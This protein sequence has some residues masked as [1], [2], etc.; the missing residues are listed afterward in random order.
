[1][2]RWVRSLLCAPPAIPTRFAQQWLTPGVN[3]S[4]ICFN[5]VVDKE[6]MMNNNPSSI[7]FVRTQT[8]AQGF[9]NGFGVLRSLLRTIVVVTIGAVAIAGCTNPAPSGTSQTLSV[10][11]SGSGSGA[12]TS[13]T[14]G[15]NCG[16]TCSAVVE[17]GSSLTLTA[18]A[19][20]GS[21]FGGWSGG[22]G[23]SNAVLAMTVNVDTVCTATFNAIPPTSTGSYPWPIWTSDTVTVP[24]SS[25]G[26]TYYVDGANGN[27]VNAGTSLSSAFKTVLKAVSS[28]Q[29][30]D[31]VLI[32][33]GL[34]REG[35][36]LINGPSG[37][38]AKPI[39]FGSYGDG[40]VILDGS[41]KVTGWSRVSGNIW[42]ASVPFTPIG[43]VV[44]DVPLKQVPQ[45]Y[46]APQAPNVGLAGVT[47]GNGKWYWDASA[48]QI[49]ADMGSTIGSSDPNN[50]DIVVPNND[51]GQTH[52]FFYDKDWV[53]FKGLTI[54][55]SGA[56][57]IWG[58]GSH[59][60]IEAC[61]IEFN[62][63]S[64]VSFQPLGD[65]RTFSDN[66]V[67]YS[68]AY[69]NV[70]TN[71]PRGNSGYAVSGGGW[72]GGGF[73]WAGNLRPAGVEATSWTRTAVRASPRISP[74]PACRAVAR[75]SNR[76]S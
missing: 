19:L 65:G 70:L 48:K 50:A 62:G 23:G 61:N 14:A 49:T 57:G 73:S 9:T 32:R 17:R 16:N 30:G 28:V 51:G 63:K 15:I 10:N 7:T 26:Q 20:S 74:S 27:D 40:E 55:G 71:W 39:T 4:E 34:Y 8:R 44:N 54:R 42:R 2:P 76:M 11:K 6:P 12:I 45:G 60:I 1:M 68:R 64:A 35:I 59:I 67:L 5:L 25:T 33:K 36:Q 75:C 31:T 22:C 3:H 13:D 56:A 37:T 18:T 58:Y 21:S 41:S 69:Q 53:T 38:Q 47:S 46:N 24:P 52:V 43:V 29:A 72:P 66:A